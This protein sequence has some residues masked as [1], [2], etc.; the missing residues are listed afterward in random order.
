[1][2]AYSRHAAHG[3]KLTDLL[4]TLADWPKARSVSTHHHRTQVE[5]ALKLLLCTSIVAVR[6]PMS[7]TSSASPLAVGIIR[8][9][10]DV[11][12]GLHP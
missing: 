3:A 8:M 2:S 9:V 10:A 6:H 5:F 4:V 7:V 11:G 12:H 1:M